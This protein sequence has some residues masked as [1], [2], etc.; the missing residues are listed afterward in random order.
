M[1]LRLI[2]AVTV[3]LATMAGRAVAQA[4]SPTTSGTEQLAF[5]RPEAWALKYFV[6]TTTLGGVETP[7]ETRAGSVSLGLEGGWIPTLSDAQQRVGFNG[8]APQDLNKAPVMLRPRIIVGL[9]GRVAITAAGNPPI[10]AFGVTPRLVSAAVEWAVVDM[11]MLRVA[12]RG[13]G[14]TGTV[15][16]AFTC[17]AAVAA[18]PPGSAANPTG[19]DGESAD[20]ATLRYVG[21]EVRIALRMLTWNGLTPHLALGGNVVDAT[22]Q[23]N[24]PAF[25]RLDRTLLTTSGFT[26]STSAGFGCALSDRVSLAVDGYYAPLTVRRSATAPQTIDSL[27]NVRA[28]VAYRWRR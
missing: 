22:Y 16:G 24:T 14:Q 13:H 8:T 9:P 27:V 11:P 4:P 26:P 15:T 2:S 23:L 5:D 20:V 28:L 18:S 6:S 7:D 3:L 19:C 1:R 10:R 17:S 25:G 21:A 12:V